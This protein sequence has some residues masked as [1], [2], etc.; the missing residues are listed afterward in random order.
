[1]NSINEGNNIFLRNLKI[2]DAYTSY[3]WRNDPIIWENTFGNMPKVVTIEDEIEWIT[4][5][6]K[7]KESLRMAI[8]TKKDKTYIGNVYLTSI[9]N[10]KKNAE[11]NI[12]IG[13][14]NYWGKGLAT[15]VCK[16]ITKSGFE[17][18]G[19]KE[20]YLFVKKENLAAIKVYEKCGFQVE[21]KTNNE[22][23]NQLKMSIANY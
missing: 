5:V 6:I 1:M 21:P 9:D 14:R 10:E 4:K 19:L 17:Q 11:F 20:I 12:F 18:L 2:E 15:E 7:Q 23:K 3:K 22:D 13:E 16:L 8:V